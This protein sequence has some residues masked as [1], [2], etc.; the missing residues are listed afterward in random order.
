MP[1][2]LITL[3]IIGVVAAI[4]IPTL[5]KNHQRQVYATQIK[6]VYSQ[7]S[8]ALENKLLDSNAVNLKEAGFSNHEGDFLKKYFKVVKDCG[9]TDTSC[10]ALRYDV[11]S[12]GSIQIT[13]TQSNDMYKVILA[14]GASIG[15]S[16]NAYYG[17]ID[18]NGIQGPN[19][20]C[21]DLFDFNIQQDGTIESTWCL[22]QLI[23]NGWV[24]D[25]YYDSIATW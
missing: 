25:E 19:I 24:M 15:L 22:G 7:L 10:F 17:W 5:V 18:A 6:T 2:V 3:G 21:R 20:A 14:N 11:L 8:E 12:N 13:T 16:V 23:E 1:E 9:T 4:T